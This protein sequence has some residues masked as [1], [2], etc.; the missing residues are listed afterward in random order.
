MNFLET[1]KNEKTI[2]IVIFFGMLVVIFAIVLF[3]WQDYNLTFSLQINA[4]KF[5]QFGD[6]IGG[7]SGSFWALAGVFLFYKALT[8]QRKDFA[9]NK[10]ALDSQV[11]AL[12]S[13][14]SEFEAQRKELA[15]SR[16]IYE[17]QSKT[18]KIQQFESSFYSFFEIYLKIKEKL[19]NIENKNDHFEQIF[20][21]LSESY[22]PS[23]I[24]SNNHRN[25][26]Q[27]Y[28]EIFEERRGSLSHYFKAF[29]RLIKM[30]ENSNLEEQH[31]I[32]YAKIIRSQLTDYEQLVLYYNSHTNYGMKAKF[33]ILKYNILKHIPIFKK[34]EFKDIYEKDHSIL[35]FTNELNIFLAKHINQSYEL[36]VDNPNAQ[37]ELFSYKDCILAI[38]FEDNMIDLEIICCNNIQNNGFKITEDQLYM[39]LYNYLYDKLILSSYQKEHLVVITK[40][41]K[42][43]DEHKIFASRIE[44][45]QK[46]ILIEE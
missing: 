44:T 25:M 12:E 36:E 27:K 46:L 40:S 24:I 29:Y 17:E 39:F 30:I 6:F 23:D 34:P 15:L 11:K 9:T 45:S 41:K 38:Y 21:Q 20:N 16:K 26:V 14:I 28:E 19:V 35:K 1:L 37:E 33:L 13:Q 4:E 7:V 18:L 22:N 5:G 31:K 3:F 10:K 32:F 8:E 2:S 43:D 42:E